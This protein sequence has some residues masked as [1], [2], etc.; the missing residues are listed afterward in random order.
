M[1][2]SILLILTLVG[3]FV[4][5]ACNFDAEENATP[6][7]DDIIEEPINPLP[8]VTEAIEPPTL[9]PSV[10]VT[11]T[12]TLSPTLT[13]TAPAP[14]E[15]TTNTPTPS[16]IPS[17]TLLPTETPGPFEHTMQADE[18]MLF[19]IQQYGYSLSDDFN[20]AIA[21]IVRLNENV[22]SADLLPGPG[23]VILIPR[24]TEPGLPGNIPTA[25]PDAVAEAGTAAPPNA[26]M[27]AEGVIIVPPEDPN[28]ELPAMR[29]NLGLPAGSFV[30][31]H[32]VREGE[33][34]SGILEQYT[35]LT[36]D[37]FS[38]LN[39]ELNWG[40]CNLELP[41]GGP[42][43]APIIV[44]NTCVNVIL[45]TPTP[46]LSPTPSGDETATP[47]PTYAPPRIISPL[48]GVTLS[49][50]VATLSWVGVG[51]LDENEVYLIQVIDVTAGTSTAFT[52]ASTTYRLPTALIPDDGQTHE[53]NWSV[54]VAIPNASGQYVPIGAQQ[55]FSFQ[56][57]SR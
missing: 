44:E 11:S 53:I 8:D 17:A 26:E 3:V 56:W 55:T 43:C 54:S 10:T 42:N 45:P 47:T 39:A 2:R 23:S 29:Q 31:C 6:T 36:L 13:P 18:T 20:N 49:A 4:L 27:N 7:T 48:D 34:V 41:S 12:P 46:T 22:I 51:A 50:G 21:E 30:G 1:Q 32:R 40:G 37:V 24:P 14:I 15:V 19:I 33:R 25:A 52:T 16:P 9:T 28:L 38:R 5:S 57:Q 35:G